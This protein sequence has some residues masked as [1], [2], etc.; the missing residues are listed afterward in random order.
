MAK[1]CRPFRSLNECVNPEYM[2]F[3]NIVTIGETITHCIGRIV[4]KARQR[5]NRGYVVTIYLPNFTGKRSIMQ[6]IFMEFSELIRG[7][8]VKLDISDEEVYYPDLDVSFCAMNVDLPD[9]SIPV[10]WD[11]QLTDWTW[12]HV[13]ANPQYYSTSSSDVWPPVH[14]SMR[15]TRERQQRALNPL[16]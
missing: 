5:Q 15:A 3:G 6:H 9:M 11:D 4:E 10:C 16:R 12:E 1:R 2:R 14:Y 7:M 13:C 8:N